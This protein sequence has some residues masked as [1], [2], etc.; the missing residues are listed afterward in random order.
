MP[1][2][3]DTQKAAKR[4]TG[5]TAEERAAMRE[6]VEEMKATAQAADAESECLAK[7]AEMPEPDCGIAKRL[8]AVIKKA[9]P[10]LSVKT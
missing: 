3:K 5:F 4:S 7:I 8:H 2:V 1:A 10:T 9:A 6:P